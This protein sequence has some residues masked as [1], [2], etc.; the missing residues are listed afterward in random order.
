MRAS[1]MNRIFGL[2][3]Q[4]GPAHLVA[5]AARPGRDDPA[6]A[7]GHARGVAALDRRGARR[8]RSARRAH[9]PIDQQLRPL[10]R[11]DARVVLLDT[12]PGVGDLLAL[13]LASEI[14]DVARS[15]RRGS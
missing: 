15:G 12:M 6:R 9:H 13:T 8:D 11:A 2:Q 7:A 14:G 4:M 1:A 3:T 5:A 10:A